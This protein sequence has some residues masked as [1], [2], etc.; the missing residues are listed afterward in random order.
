MLKKVKIVISL[1][2]STQSH[3]FSKTRNLQENIVGK[4][5]KSD[6][7]HIQIAMMR[8]VDDEYLIELCETL[9]QELEEVKAFDLELNK[10][11]W[12]PNKENPKMIWLKGEKSDELVSLRNVVE[13]C[14][15]E[16]PRPVNNFSPHITLAKVPR[17]GYSGEID[18][19]KINT[20]V[21]LSVDSLDVIE[22]SSEGRSKNEVLL[23][24]IP[25]SY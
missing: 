8:M 16:N 9:T 6:K 18:L 14:L 25:L 13:R 3:I 11:V 17:K 20:S 15:N 19:E 2:K 7:Y 4:W 12:G 24:R 23:Q 1:D 22:I 21:V 10:I 5:L